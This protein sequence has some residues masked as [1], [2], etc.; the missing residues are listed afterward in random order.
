MLSH[1]RCSVF[2]NCSARF[3]IRFRSLSFVHGIVD[4]ACEDRGIVE[5]AVSVSG[6]FLV[7][8]SFEDQRSESI[9]Y[10]E[11]HGIVVDLDIAVHGFA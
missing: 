6:I 4:C 5:V 2:F 1:D 7:G 3:L 9:G 10:A 11:S 8:S